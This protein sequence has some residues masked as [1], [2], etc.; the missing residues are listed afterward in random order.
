M[1][2]A[3]SSFN[4]NDVDSISSTAEERT[5]PRQMAVTHP[6]MQEDFNARQGGSGRHR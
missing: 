4:L 1:D 2:P 6:D 3:E 5:R